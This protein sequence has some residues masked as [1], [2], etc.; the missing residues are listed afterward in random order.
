MK[1]R[2][3]WRLFLEPVSNAFDAEAKNVNVTISREARSPFVVFICEDDGEGFTN[4]RL[5]YTFYANTDRRTNPCKRGR[6]TVGE[7]AFLSI[8]QEGMIET[9]DKRVTF[10]NKGDISV[11]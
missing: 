8:C 5:A 6:F 11:P 1:G 10:D 7:K 2:Q 4:I 9:A 3:L